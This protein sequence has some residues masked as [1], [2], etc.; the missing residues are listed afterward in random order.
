MTDESTTEGEKPTPADRQVE[1][2]F[3]QDTPAATPAKA[4][5]KRSGGRKAAGAKK[6]TAKKAAAKK[7]AGAKKATRAA[8]GKPRAIKVDGDPNTVKITCRTCGARKLAKAFPTVSGRQDGANRGTQCRA[9]RD[10]DKPK[11][12]KK[13]A[14]A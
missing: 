9:C 1:P 11:A 14:K 6:G 13:A 3:K 5:A 2:N 4:T 8:D 7:A 12:A 10:A